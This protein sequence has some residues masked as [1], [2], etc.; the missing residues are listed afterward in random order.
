[1]EADADAEI[2]GDVVTMVVN[3]APLLQ[4]PTV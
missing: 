3:T 4:V 2:A 1:M